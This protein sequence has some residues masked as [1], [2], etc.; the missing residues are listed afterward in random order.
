MLLFENAYISL[1]FYFTISSILALIL[2]LL[3]LVLATSNISQEHEKVSA[4]ECGFEPFSDVRDT[5]D[6]H[7]IVVAILFIIF[8]L[9]LIFIFPWAIGITNLTFF[10][11]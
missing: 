5:F 7:F 11:F 3:P 6:I 1:F 8:D 4:Y 9:E 10:G 2:F